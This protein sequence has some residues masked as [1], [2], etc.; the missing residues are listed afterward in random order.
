[1]QPKKVQQAPKRRRRRVPLVPPAR[2]RD[3]WRAIAFLDAALEPDW[4]MR[5]YSFDARWAPGE[6]VGFRRNGEG[7]HVEAWFSRRGVVLRGFLL[8]SPMS[9]LRREGELWPGLLKGLPATL[10]EAVDEPAFGE[11]EITF[12]LWARPG[13]SAWGSGSAVLA[14]DVEDADG[15]EYL[16]EVLSGDPRAYAAHA[17]RHF[18]RQL[19]IDLVESVYRAARSGTPL[20]P[21]VV[22][23]LQP[24]A[25]PR[26]L[27]GTAKE[28]ELTMGTKKTAPKKK[29]KVVK[30]APAKRR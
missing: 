5:Q 13:V 19:D 9:A 2:L 12:C 18:D 21:E 14:R 1:M 10:R 30:K 29:A 17:A 28:L 25:T 16:L 7:D 4:E 27:G 8:D 26:E 6:Q 3:L 22:E 24:R 23:R 15:A 20:D 11:A